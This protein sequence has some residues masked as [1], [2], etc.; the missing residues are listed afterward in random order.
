[1][2]Q[3]SVVPDSPPPFA[4]PFECA[5]STRGR[6]A[7]WVRVAGELD[8]HTA[9]QLKRA[10]RAARLRARLTVLDTRA[11]SFI[12][13][14]GLHVILSASAGSQLPRLITVPGPIVERLLRL[15][16]VHDQAWTFDL[17]PTEHDPNPELVSE[18]P[19]A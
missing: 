1:M 2:F 18:V 11:V 6:R 10:L 13:C 17:A 5:V 16:H 3:T 19:A 7:S 9:P 15:T 8:F 4:A 12:D 14:C